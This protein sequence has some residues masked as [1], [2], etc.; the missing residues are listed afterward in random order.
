M[1]TGYFC[2]IFM[3]L[4]SCTDSANKHADRTENISPPAEA[5]DSFG[6]SEVIQAV[7]CK[8]NKDLSYALYLPKQYNDTSGLPCIIFADPH[9]GGYY[10]LTKYHSF[11]ES[12]GVIL[13]GSNDSKNGIS[14]DVSTSVL[15]SLSDE[16]VTRF[17]ADPK[18]ISFA[19]FSGGA[20]A[21]LVAASELPSLLSIIYCGAGLP[22]VPPLL[23]PSLAITGL[24]DMNY[25]EVINTDHLLEQNHIQHS[26]IE[27]NG[28]HEWS[29]SGTFINAFYWT[30]FRAMEKKITNISATMIHEFIRLNSKAGTSPLR[31]ELRLK[32]LSGFLNGVADISG[33]VSALH[34]LTGTKNYVTAKEKQQNESGIETR[35]KQNYLQCINIKDP[36]WWRDE[37]NHMRSLKP[38]PMN[39]RILAYIS[40][41]CYS[42]SGNA[43]KQNDLNAA[44]KY[45]SIYALVDR[46]NSD[47]AYMQACLYARMQNTV[48]AIQSIREA[49]NYGFSDKVRLMS[50]PAFAQLKNTAAFNEIYRLIK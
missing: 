39:D 22:E 32:K 45:L 10:P 24:K 23:P 5:I 20:K 25:T 36:L 6:I 9:G 21:V 16:A 14:F 33:Y 28:K 47:R 18:Q 44:E 13:I 41:A 29:D 31:E 2:F 7:Q 1:K 19:G 4:L 26:L 43:L 17:R 49:I 8:I 48:G 37:V 46:E 34:S 42:Y 27:W 30:R 35:M 50:E 40:L 12:F 11:A 38:D 15:K 3:L